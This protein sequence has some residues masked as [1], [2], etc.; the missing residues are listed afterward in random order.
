M[1]LPNPSFILS[2]APLDVPPGPLLLATPEAA[3]LPHSC[4]QPFLWLDSVL[5]LPQSPALATVFVT[6]FPFLPILSHHLSVF[7]ENRP[8]PIDRT[9]QC[10]GGSLAQGLH[11]CSHSSAAMSGSSN[12][13]LGAFAIT[14]SKV[15]L[16]VSWAVT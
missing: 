9:G 12:M 16:I 15:L 5:E 4:R 1:S 7:T 10:R 6:P 2:R 3:L 11:L 14:K 13:S 8:G